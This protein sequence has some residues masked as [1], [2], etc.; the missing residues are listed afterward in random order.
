MIVYHG[1]DRIIK[2]PSSQKGRRDVDI[3]KGFYL[4][5]D[6]RMAQKWACNKVKSIVNEYEMDLSILKVKHLK[7]DEEWLD[8]VAYNR[9]REGSSPFEDTC[10]DVILGPTADDKLFATLDLYADGVLSKKQAIKVINC[11]NYSTQIV[12]KN[13]AAIESALVF[14]GAKELRGFEKQ[15]IYAQMIEDRKLASRRALEEI[16]KG[17]ENGA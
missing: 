10:Y 12:F 7:V 1:T 11:M 3:G 4:T 5:E 8:Y 17:G 16:R 2:H 13:D 6:K 14:K 9:T 15:N